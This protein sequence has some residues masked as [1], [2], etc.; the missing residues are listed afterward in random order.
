[1]A[2]ARQDLDI[3]CKVVHARI[4]QKGQEGRGRG[5]GILPSTIGDYLNAILSN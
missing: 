3:R 4:V 5:F 2:G 1:M